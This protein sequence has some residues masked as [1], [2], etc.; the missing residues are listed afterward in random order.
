M[1][2]EFEQRDAIVIAVSQ[3]DKDLASAAKFLDHFDGKPKFQIVA[4][5]GRKA[6]PRYDHTTTYVIDKDGKVRQIF[7]GIVHARANWLAVLDEVQLIRA[8]G[9]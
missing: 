8:E 2:D 7:P 3:E 6:T 1:Y 5:I 4:D 9:Y